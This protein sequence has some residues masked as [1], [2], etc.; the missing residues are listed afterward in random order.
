MRYCIEREQVE[1]SGARRGA[2]RARATSPFGLETMRERENKDQDAL[3]EHS[4]YDQA[5]CQG[6]LMPHVS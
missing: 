3:P 2:L 5:A 6:S 1:Q 4:R